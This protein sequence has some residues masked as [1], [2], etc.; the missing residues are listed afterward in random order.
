MTRKSLIAAVAL[1][2]FQLCPLLPALAQLPNNPVPVPSFVSTTKFTNVNVTGLLTNA[3]AKT[4]VQSVHVG[5]AAL[6]NGT[7]F[8][9]LIPFAHAGTI[10]GISVAANVVPIGGTNTLTVYE[11]ISGNNL[12]STTN[13]NP[14]TIAAANTSQALPLT[15]T[16]ANL[17]LAANDGVLVTYV[18]GTQTTAAV[19]PVITVQFVPTDF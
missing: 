7:T 5:S 13:F 1:G 16:T 17:S 6:A 3:G 15:A 10:T 9:Y 18:S 11:A 8:T 4:I 14:T 12:L 19:A 2:L